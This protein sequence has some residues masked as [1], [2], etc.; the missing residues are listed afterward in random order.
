MKKPFVHILAVTVFLSLAACSSTTTTPEPPPT[1]TTPEPLTGNGLENTT[2][3]LEYY[4]EPDNL[5]GILSGTEIT[6]LFDNAENQMRGS[7]GGKDY[8]GSYQINGDKI[9]IQE[10]GPPELILASQLQ[11]HDPAGL[12]DVEGDWTPLE[13]QQQYFEALQDVE[14]FQI[15]GGKLQIS[16]SNLILIYT[17]E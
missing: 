12:I 8:F 2:W 3:I 1:T 11:T 13:Q 16:C 5:R 4:G 9:S 15:Q 10:V 14:S 17:A 6:A 7:V